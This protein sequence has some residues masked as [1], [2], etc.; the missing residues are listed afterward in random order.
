MTTQPVTDEYA[1]LPAWCRPG[2]KVA[3]F[4]WAG[5]Q[6]R[7]TVTVAT[8]VRILKTRVV[9]RFVVRGETIEDWVP[10][11][12]S[13]MWLLSRHYGHGAGHRLA[14][15]ASQEVRDARAVQ[16]ANALALKIEK[17]F[18][19]RTGSGQVR[20]EDRKPLGNAADALALLDEI[21]D[22]IAPVRAQLQAQLDQEGA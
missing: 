2:R 14:D 7:D 12:M 11:T 8:V 16:Q 5:G 15:P 6:S 10:R 9:V 21:F 3:M 20:K 19:V 4:S 1:D 17:V 13:G 22:L 18:D